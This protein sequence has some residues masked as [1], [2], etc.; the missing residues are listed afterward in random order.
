MLKI[1]FKQFTNFWKS[2]EVRYKLELIILSVIFFAFISS[3]ISIALGS[4]LQ[5]GATQ[6]GISLLFANLF[7]F[8]INVSSLA[9]I[10]WLLPNQKTLKTL[11]M[12]PLDNK[13]T[14]QVLI[15]YSLKYLSFY[16]ILLLPVLTALSYQATVWGGLSLDGGYSSMA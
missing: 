10:A 9:I 6:S 3:R 7:S 1:L 16:I 5:D 13:K 8:L 14:F 2:L 15:F 11:L 12:Q 4:W